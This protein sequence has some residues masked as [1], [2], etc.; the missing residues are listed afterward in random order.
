MIALIKVIDKYNSAATLH[1]IKKGEYIC[2]NFPEQLE[3]PIIDY[4]DCNYT[5]ISKNNFSVTFK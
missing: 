5:I 3:H 1:E 4:I 2:S